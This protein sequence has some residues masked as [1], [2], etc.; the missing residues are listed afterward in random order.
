[1]PRTTNPAQRMVELMAVD[2]AVLRL[3]GA[4]Q[5]LRVTVAAAGGGG[6]Q[7]ITLPE[8]FS[9]EKED[10]LL[11][12]LSGTVHRASL[13]RE[14]GQ[15]YARHSLFGI[16]A[17]LAHIAD[18]R[19]QCPVLEELWFHESDAAAVDAPAVVDDAAY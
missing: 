1:M 11:D 3:R 19:A 15:A 18:L 13:S 4:P 10:L 7:T 9:R 12:A 17:M 14:L 2:D 6:Y 16:H 5:L 8:V